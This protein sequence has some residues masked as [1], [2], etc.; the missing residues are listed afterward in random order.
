[1]IS[2]RKPS[3]EMKQ[4]DTVIASSENRSQKIFCSPFIHSTRDGKERKIFI[5]KKRNIYL[6]KHT[7]RIN[8][9]IKPSP[10]LPKFLFSL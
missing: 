3:Q 6:D 4:S 1:M 8:P 9:M 10:T 5:K 7:N 2:R